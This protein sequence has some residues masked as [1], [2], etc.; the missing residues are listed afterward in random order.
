MW[1]RSHIFWCAL[2]SFSLPRFSNLCY[3]RDL[4]IQFQVPEDYPWEWHPRQS[5]VYLRVSVTS[6][7][8][9]AMLYIGAT[10]DTVQRREFARRRK[11]IQLVRKKLSH[12]EPALKV[13]HRKRNFYKGILIALHHEADGLALFSTE[14]A[15][16][17]AVRPHLNYPWV[18]DVM[19]RLRIQQVRFR[20]PQARTGLRRIRKADALIRHHHGAY[21]A[22]IT[23]NKDIFLS[24]YRLGSDS[25]QK[26]EESRRLRSHVVPL[27]AIYLRCRLVAVIDEPFRTRAISQLRL[28][29]EFRKGHYPP[30]NVPLRLPPLAHD[31]AGE[32]QCILR[33]LV[34]RERVNFPPLHLPFVK[35]VGIKGRPW[36]KSVFNFRT[37]LRSW[38]PGKPQECDCRMWY[39]EN[40]R[41]SFSHVRQIL[42]RSPLPDLNLNDTTFLSDKQW[43]RIAD[44]EL[45]LWCNRWRLPDRIRSG[46]QQWMQHQLQLH[47]RALQSENLQL[48]R[49]I[50]RDLGQLRGLV[51]TPV[52]H[53]PHSLHVAC[54]FAFHQLL[55]TTFLDV[56]VFHRCSVGMSSIMSNLR[57]HF[58]SFSPD[59]IRDMLGDASGLHLCQWHAFYLNLARPS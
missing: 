58:Q 47:N 17:H 38:T 49:T 4:L 21:H 43:A 41:Q 1:V 29:L 37:F 54:P 20:M 18:Q 3:I 19:K 40:T 5:M 48:L 50:Q 59:G 27:Q 45:R 33:F 28:I 22:R 16:I 11:F 55:D 2:T 15:L 31:L 12:Y 44:K 14:A 10:S 8:H 7:L 23:T 30:T 42:P 35:M 13:L 34:Q 36:S 25:V 39:K 52:D 56:T 32:V 6:T 46:L 53:F 57:S 51:C 26:F 9:S 24:L